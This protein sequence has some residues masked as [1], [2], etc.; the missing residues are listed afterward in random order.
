MDL[1]KPK[2]EGD[3]GLSPDALVFANLHQDIYLTLAQAAQHLKSE[4]GTIHNQLS[5]KKKNH[6]IKNAGFFKLSGKLVI[7]VQRLANFLE[8]QE[9]IN[10]L[11]RQNI[12]R[13]RGGLTKA[14][15]IA[16]R[17]AEGMA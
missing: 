9:H 8:E 11:E 16:K 14:E 3:L 15:Q 10:R 1:T 7:H 5:D 2:F 4:P 6:P 12:P 13:R 17:Q